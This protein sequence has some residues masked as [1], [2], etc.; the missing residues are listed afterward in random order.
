M[1]TMSRILSK[2]IDSRALLGH[3]R[4]V[5]MGRRHRYYD[6]TRHE[7]QSDQ[8]L[9]RRRSTWNQGTPETAEQREN[10]QVIFQ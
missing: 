2:H 1:A 4:H 3:A 9:Q 5:T 10:Y 6:K 7:T 8:S